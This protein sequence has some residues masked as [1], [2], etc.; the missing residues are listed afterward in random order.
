MSIDKY[1]K[2]AESISLT[3]DDIDR[4][5]D[6]KCNILSYHELE[7]FT[8]LEKV[9][10]KWNACIF[11]YETKLNQGHWCCIF[12]NTDNSLHFFDS[13]GFRC[14]T[15]LKYADYNLR[16]HNGRQVPH[17]SGLIDEFME[18]YPEVHLYQNTYKYQ[19]MSKDV[20]TCGRY[21]SYRIKMRHLSDN[22]FQAMLTKNKHYNSDWWI[23]LLTVQL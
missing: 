2:K 5:T 12:L 4:I 19:V 9:L 1:I 11:L 16:E 8:N 20:N 23:S 18:R 21:A 10:G 14:D 7:Q 13:Y 6:K 17:L 15:E 22:D 3:G